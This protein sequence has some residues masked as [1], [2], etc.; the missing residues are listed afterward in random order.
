V[1]LYAAIRP[2][3]GMGPKTAAMGAFAFWLVNVGFQLA[4]NGM[5]L[6]PTNLIVMSTIASL[7]GMVLAAQAGA[8][9]YKE[10]M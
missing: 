10:G 5:G 6:F 3:Y 7:V 1:W 9:Q 2:R 4:Q 8:W